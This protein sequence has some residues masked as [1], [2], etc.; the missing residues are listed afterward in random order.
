MV[1][2]SALRNAGS[3]AGMIL[4]SEAIVAD[5]EEIGTIDVSQKLPTL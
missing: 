4:T 2:K 5:E 1:T 3:V